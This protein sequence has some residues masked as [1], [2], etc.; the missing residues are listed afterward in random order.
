MKTQHS[1]NMNLIDQDLLM[2]ENNPVPMLIYNLEKTAVTKANRAAAEKFGYQRNEEIKLNNL[3][4]DDYALLKKVLTYTDKLQDLGEW[5]LKIKSGAIIPVNI[6][7]GTVIL[8]DKNFILISITYSESFTKA[9]LSETEK[10]LNLIVK[11]VPIILFAINKEGNFIFA[12]GESVKGLKYT[13]EEIQGKSALRL[14]GKMNVH[15]DTGNIISGKDV[16]RRVLMNKK[17][18]GTI[19]LGKFYFDSRFTPLKSEFGQIIGVIGTAVNI[20]ERKL[21]EHEREKL[22]REVI[23]TEAK[24]KVLSRKLI[25]VQESERKHIARE[26]HDDIGQILTAIKIETQ[27]ALKYTGK[28]E[29]EIHLNEVVQLL[30][31]ALNQ[32]RNLSRDLRPSLIDD[33]GII[34]AIRWYLDKEGLRSGIKIKILT[35]IEKI[36]L[37]S[38]LEITCFRLVQEAFTNIARHAEATA[39]TVEIYIELYELHLR[40]RDNGKGFDVYTTVKNAIKGRSMGVL[41]MQERV[42]LV[43]GKLKISSSSKKGTEIH[44]IFPLE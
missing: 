23:Q 36:N 28:K 26:L 4:V 18:A 21:I 15:E 25:E 27:T 16:F 41:G 38:E 44:A 35:D 2:F 43:G 11:N 6:T 33:V 32:V 17:V 9:A 30:E 37:R 12:E 5:H 40:V 20:T 19:Q 34:P 8:N 24:L 31:H 10:K 29:C 14:F 42:E 39:V 1:I 3:F 22:L 13:P 7:I